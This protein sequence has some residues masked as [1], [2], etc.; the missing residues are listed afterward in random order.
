[1]NIESRITQL[2]PVFQAIARDFANGDEDKADDILQHICTVVL[3]NGRPDQTDAELR[4]LA[5]WRAHHYIRNE[6]TVAAHILDCYTWQI[7]EDIEDENDEFP[8]PSDMPTPEAAIIWKETNERLQEIISR[9]PVRHQRLVGL[10]RS[11][12]T[13]ATISRKMGVSRAAISKSMREI[14]GAFVAAGFSSW[15]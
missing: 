12:Y 5:R 2:L 13:P 6:R 3:T 11:G 9:L 8:V 4:Q 14:Q 10:L 7:G 1:M 15:R